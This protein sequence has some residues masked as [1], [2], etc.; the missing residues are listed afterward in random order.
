VTGNPPVQI[1]IWTGGGSCRK[2]RTRRRITCGRLHRERHTAP[3]SYRRVLLG[4]PPV[5]FGAESH[6]RRM[7]FLSL[8]QQLPNPQ[9]PN[10]PGRLL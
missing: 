1:P 9:S 5:S 4:A 7:Q 3:G 2:R 6:N 10:P 8:N